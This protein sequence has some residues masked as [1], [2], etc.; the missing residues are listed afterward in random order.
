MGQARA[1]LPPHPDASALPPAPPLPPES[2]GQQTPWAPALTRSEAWPREA[3]R[4]PG[5]GLRQVLGLDPAP[6]LGE[7]GCPGPW[8]QS[9]DGPRLA[10]LPGGGRS[11]MNRNTVSLESGPGGNL[12]PPPRTLVPRDPAS[13]H[14]SEPHFLLCTRRPLQAGLMSQAAHFS[15]L[16]WL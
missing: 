10:G 15:Q 9:C 3:G 7:P 14:L 4:L 6:A 5:T 16:W 13:R 2:P 11:A 8:G 12:P 1:M